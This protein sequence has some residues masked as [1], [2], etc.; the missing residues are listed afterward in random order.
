MN[1]KGFTAVFDAAMFIV[2]ISIAANLIAVT[3][4]HSDEEVEIQEPSDVLERVFSARVDCA[5]IGMDDPQGRMSMNRLAYVSLSAGDGHF[6]EYLDVL[7]SSLYPWPDSFGVEIE[8]SGRSESLGV[9]GGE[10]WRTAEKVFETGYSDDLH[11]T[12]RVYA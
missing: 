4:A 9:T 12:L 11:V 7:L 6:L 2:L 3:L 1:R 8:W 10:P 5:D